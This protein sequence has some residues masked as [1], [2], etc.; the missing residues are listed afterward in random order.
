MSVVTK[1]K[2]YEVINGLPDDVSDH[3]QVNKHISI[4]IED[5]CKKLNV[6]CMTV[7]IESPVHNPL[8]Q[9]ERLNFN[10]VESEAGYDE[11]CAYRKKY[12]TPQK[13]VVTI[14]SYPVRNTVFSDEEISDIDEISRLIFYYGTRSRA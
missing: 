5:V 9:G 11:E 7:S 2:I 12:V 8:T 10:L 14:T 1:E 3:N 4:A 13:C 6:G